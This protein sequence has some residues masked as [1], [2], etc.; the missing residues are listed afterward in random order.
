MRVK[1]P[2]VVVG[3]KLDLIDD[4]QQ[5]SLGHVISHI[6]QQFREIE[7]SIEC[8]AYKHLQ[9]PEVFYHAQKAVLHPVAPL[10]DKETQ[11][12]KDRYM[13]ALKRIFIQCDHDKDGALGDAELNDLQVKCFNAP[14]QPSEIWDVKRTVQEKLP[15]GVSERGL[16]LI[17]F[18]VLHAVFVEKGCT[19][20]T[21]TVLRKF[22]YN[23][24]LRLSEELIPSLPKRNP[25]QIVELTNEAIE[26]LS[27]T[28]K[29]FDCDGDGALRPGELE[30]LFSTAPASIF[31]GFPYD[32]AFGAISLERFLSR[33]ALM[34][35]QYPALTME[36]LVYLG[37]PGDI[38]SAIR[39]TTKR[40]IDHKK[41]QTNRN[42]YQC[43]VFGP[44]KALLDFFLGRSFSEIYDATTKEHYAVNVVHQPEGTKKFMVLKEVPED[45]INKLLSSKEALAAC[46]LAVFV[47][48]SSERATELLVEVASHAENSGFEVPCLI[49]AATDNLDS[50]SLDIQHST[51]VS[52]DMA[53]IPVISK[54][55]D[56]TN[57]FHEIVSVAEYSNLSILET[58]AGRGCSPYQRLINSLF[59]LVSGMGAT[60]G[61]VGLAAYCFY[62]L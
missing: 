40:R 2:V 38:S 10:C 35:L 39:V 62:A 42:V 8:S 46:D 33:W 55:C 32:G 23:N 47:H 25:N 26:F 50:F 57:V 61:V 18:L 36:N 16:T 58:R 52:K 34:A 12:L 41:K 20:T 11:T 59:M 29:F 44:T 15:E 7:T 56:F 49:V 21:W 1:V 51:R 6:M 19:D 37:F 31:G 24:E 9:V 30:Q 27:A 5:A 13:R 43:F 17:G 54:L 3:C 4:R 48:D 28:F 45:G 14:L 22:G 53:P 60:A